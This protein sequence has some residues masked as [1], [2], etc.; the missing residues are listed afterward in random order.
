MKGGLGEARELG[1]GQKGGKN[2]DGDGKEMGIDNEQL[3]F[4]S[5]LFS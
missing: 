5:P 4:S 2:G 1:A 3:Q